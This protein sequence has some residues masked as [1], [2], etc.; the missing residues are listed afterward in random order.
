MV[1]TPGDL[2]FS[3]VPV[4]EGLG[5]AY[6]DVH[7]SWRSC[8]HPSKKKKKKTSHSLRHLHATLLLKW[9]GSFSALSLNIFMISSLILLQW[10]LGASLGDLGPATPCLGEGTQCSLGGFPAFQARI[11]WWKTFISWLYY[12]PPFISYFGS[13]QKKSFP[14]R[15]SESP[16]PH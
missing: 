10:L 7:F 9:G 13:W 14:V 2:Y 12:R 6:T 16:A 4:P 1:P 8:I 3:I 5:L 15:H 11:L